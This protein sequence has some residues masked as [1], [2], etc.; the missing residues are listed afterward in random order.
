MD[1][2]DNSKNYEVE[3][4]G[5]GVFI[6]DG[7][8]YLKDFTMKINNDLRLWEKVKVPIKRVWVDELT[9]TVIYEY[10]YRLSIAKVWELIGQSDVPLIDTYLTEYY[11]EKDSDGNITNTHLF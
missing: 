1:I 6:M 8:K 2:F 9:E 3:V 5:N 4:F 7:E 11:W 10:R